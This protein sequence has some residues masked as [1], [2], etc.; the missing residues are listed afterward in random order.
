MAQHFICL[1]AAAGSA[2]HSSDRARQRHRVLFHRSLC[3]YCRGGVQHRI[4]RSSTPATT[5]R[6]NLPNGT[7]FSIT[8]L[9]TTPLFLKMVPAGSAPTGNSQV[10]LLYQSDLDNLDVLVG[11]D[12]TGIDIIA[13]TTT[14]PLISNPNY[15]L[16]PGTGDF[17]APNRHGAGHNLLAPPHQ[18][19]PGHFLIPSTF[20]FSPSGSE[21]YIVTSDQG[22]LVYNFAPNPSVP[23]HSVEAPLPSS[24]I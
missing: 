8:G 22:V 12:N 9:P 24:R 18:S 20:L 19:S 13:T 10:P 14:T 5:C 23:S 4:S 2:N 1:L 15:L 16:V 3:F 11:V 6:A 17:A 7:P 21:I